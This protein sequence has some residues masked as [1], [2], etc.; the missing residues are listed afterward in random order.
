MR[1]RRSLQPD[2]ADCALEDRLAPAISNL[3]IIVLTTGGYILLT[4]FPGA[5]TSASGPATGPG[6]SAAAGVSGTPINTPFF[7][8]GTGGISSALPGNLTGFP[9][10]G[11]GGPGAP[12]P[13][14]GSTI[15]VGSGANEATQ[16]RIPL[17]TRNTIANDLLNPPPLIGGR[18]SG[19]ASAFPT[20]AAPTPPPAPAP[21]A[22]APSSGTLGGSTMPPPG[23]SLSGPF[24]R[25]P[26]MFPGGP[27]PGFAGGPPSGSAPGVSMSPLA[28]L[29]PPG[30]GRAGTDRG[31]GP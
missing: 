10:L 7:M 22:P 8:L 20:P 24:V 25:F 6:S 17:V 29:P 14:A 13:G 18:P 2:L 28:P 23:S 11:A 19:T 21:P 1:P 9:S 30:A 4:P 27:S 3:G 31:G 12:S 5:M 26:S 15:Y 16:P